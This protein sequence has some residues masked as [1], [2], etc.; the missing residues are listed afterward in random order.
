MEKN[1]ISESEW[2]VME[3]IW[4]LNPITAADVVGSLQGTADWKGQ[5]IRTLLSR[6]VKKGYVRMFQQGNFYL[7]IPLVDREQVVKE[8]SEGF[9][10]R[11]FAGSAKPLML[12]FV[13]QGKLSSQERDELLKAL[14]EMETSGE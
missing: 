7:Y 8:E 10:N 3:K 6:L 1:R 2:K 11:V 14:K 5:T 12:H 9:L 13:E 4:E